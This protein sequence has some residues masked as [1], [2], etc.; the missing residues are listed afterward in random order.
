MQLSRRFGAYYASFRPTP[1]TYS[2]ISS[3]SSRSSNT[4]DAGVGALSS[5]RRASSASIEVFFAGASKRGDADLGVVR[6]DE[7]PREFASKR[8]SNDR[9]LFV[10]PRQH[11][12][13]KADK[14]SLAQMAGVPLILYGE[15]SRTR[16]RVMNRLSAYGASIRVEVEGRSAALAYVRAGVGATFLSLLPR[17][18][19]DLH[20]LRARDVSSLFEPSAFYVIATKQRWSS[21]VIVDVVQ[22]LSKH[23]DA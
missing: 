2:F 23:A 20:G 3:R 9:L 4:C 11:P 16:A 6:G 7:S 13:A 18:T 1:A 10:V 15:T 12:L 8:I 5:E 22:A 17:H 14:L 21:P 19:I